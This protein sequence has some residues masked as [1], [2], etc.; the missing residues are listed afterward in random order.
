[1]KMSNNI[2]T[3]N[4]YVG[5][6]LDLNKVPPL[7]GKMPKERASELYKLLMQTN[8]PLYLLGNSGTGKTLTGKNLVKFYCNRQSKLL[9]RDVPGYYLQ[10]SQDDTKSSVFVG[11]R[12]MNGS[13]IPFDGLVARVAQEG[14]ILFVDEIT[15][16]TE[17]MILMFNAID[18]GDS[19]ITIGDRII[20]A[21]NLKI[22][23]GSNRSNHGGN[24]RVPPSFANRVIGYPFE[25]PGL[26]DETEISLATAQ[27]KLTS[28]TLNI[29]R[30]VARYISAFVIANRS[31]EWPLSSRNVAHALVMLELEKKDPLA[32][33]SKYFIGSSNNE[34]LRRQ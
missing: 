10:L 24:I 5:T 9:G 21:S 13:L 18:G 11:L 2:P 23:Y 16:S 7:V 1:M 27:A 17:N 19:V 26:E 30:S 29:P 8:I 22:I 6:K 3:N 34:S 12:M 31:N 20:D 28:K 33:T 25:Y 15:H 4:L 14:G 32:T